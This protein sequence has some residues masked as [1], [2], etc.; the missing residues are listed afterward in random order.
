MKKLHKMTT[1]KPI[2]ALMVKA[3]E[4][5]ARI[6]R[7]NFRRSRDY[8]NKKSHIDIV[9]QT[10][11]E[12]QKKIHEF[13]TLGMKDLG[14][15]D[16]EIGFVEEESGNNKIKHHNFIVDP[17]DG[18]TNF[19]SGI[20]FSCVSIGYALGQK[21]KICVVFEPFSE[22]MY[23]GEINN[24]SFVSS[25]LL[26]ERRLRLQIKPMKTW[27]IGAPLTGLEVVNTQFAMYRK[28]YPHVRGLRNVGSLTLDLCFMADNVI[29]VVF[30]MGCYFWD[31][32]AASVILNEAGGAIYDN[33]SQELKFDWVNTKKKYHLMACHPQIKKEVLSLYI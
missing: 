5:S 22:T 3:A 11:L 13:L 4:K 17:I 10:D 30:N 26:G 12:S 9:T 18:T 25:H 8:E 16:A 24:V 32:A 28:I 23:W 15:N 19:S 33:Q 1:S 21:I 7:D 2:L 6:I 27:I 20:P 14:F 29:D 31:L